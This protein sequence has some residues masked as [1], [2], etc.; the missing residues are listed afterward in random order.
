MC[1]PHEVKSI[2]LQDEEKFSKILQDNKNLI[3]VLYQLN[4]KA[5]EVTDDDLYMDVQYVSMEKRTVYSSVSEAI[6]TTFP[7]LIIIN[8]FSP[9]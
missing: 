2:I 7:R 4:R 9:S 6:P 8:K 1:T 5:H 3:F